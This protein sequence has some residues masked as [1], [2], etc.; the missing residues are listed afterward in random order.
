MD[1]MAAMEAYVLVVD[2]G[3]FSAAA[4][5]LNVGQP[6]VS[7]S[8]AQLEGRLG[9]KLLARSTH[10]LTPTEAGIIFYE[11][12]RRSIEE[13]EEADLA[14]RGAAAGFTGKLR[15]C[16]AVTFARIHLIPR[17]PEFLARHPD[18][19]LEM[20][21][22]DRNID[23]VQEGIDVALRMGRLVDSTLTARRIASGTPR[24][25]WDAGLF[26]AGGGEPAA[27]GDLIAHE[28]VIYAQRGGGAGWTFRREGGELAVTVKGRLHVTAAE[29]MRGRARRRGHRYRFRMD[30]RA[31]A[32]GWHGQSGAPRLG[33]AAARSLGGVPN[34]S[35]GDDQGAHLHQLCRRSD[36][37]TGATGQIGSR[38]SC[39]TGPRRYIG[40]WERSNA[41]Q[42]LFGVPVG[43]KPSLL[44]NT[45]RMAALIGLPQSTQLRS[46]G[47]RPGNPRARRFCG[48]DAGT[49]N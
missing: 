12:A 29:G 33:I 7:R 42:S 15:I 23:L 13:A 28:A 18:L 6:A 32:R 49:G 10:R 43:R 27:P 44:F 37:A 11:R 25:S 39:G 14:T 38:R 19:E 40:V 26:R 41:A 9:V 31:R 8:V 48:F 16:A 30:V 45:P 17:L 24:S 47:E 2:S 1:R 22:D 20:V 4:H 21:L 3:S 34:R 5:R 36:E 46:I 35:D